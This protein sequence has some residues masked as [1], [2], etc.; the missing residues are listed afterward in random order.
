MQ[1]REASR[2]EDETLCLARLVDINP[3]PLLQVTDSKGI[4]KITEKRM[5]KFLTLLDQFIGIPPGMIFLPGPKLNKRGFSWAPNSWMREESKQVAEPIFV[6][7]QKVSFLTRNGLLVQYPG[8][9][10][11]PGTGTPDRNFW[12]PTA[13]NLSEWYRIEYLPAQGAL[14]E[15]WESIWQCAC[16]DEELPAIIRS[17]FG[18]HDEPEI[19]LL[20][21][22]ARSRNS[23]P[24]NARK[25][26]VHGGKDVKWVQS[27]CRVWIQWETD[28]SVAAKLTES[29]RYNIDQMA[30]GE[31]LDEEQ[32]WVVDGHPDCWASA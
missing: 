21:R 18:R 32:R 10:L 23:A 13:R 7:E 28:H 3:L 12:I 22:G 19:A 1:W 9:Q 29:F 4:K 14:I 8:I 24:V 31:V 11:H 27:L 25:V 16:N 30:W 5:V 26:H 6:S 15:D 2:P 20:V 17:R